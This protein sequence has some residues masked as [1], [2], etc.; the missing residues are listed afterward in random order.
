MH[1]NIDLGEKGPCCE[2]IKM[3]S[4]RKYY[5]TIHYSGEKPL[6]LPKEGTMTVKFH[7]QSE[8]TTESDGKTHYSCTIEVREIVH[9]EGEAEA[10]YKSR[11][12]DAESALD[13]LMDALKEKY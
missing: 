8:T 7:K 12:K 4:D 5:P 11:S 1:M 13:A 10:P 9:V 3:D 2:P 6:D